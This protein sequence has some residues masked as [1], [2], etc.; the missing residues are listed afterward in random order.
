MFWFLLGLGA[1]WANAQEPDLNPNEIDNADFTEIPPSELTEDSDFQIEETPIQFSGRYSWSKLRLSKAICALDV[2]QTGDIIVMSCSG[3]VYKMLRSGSW[4]QVLGRSLESEEL[5]PEQILLDAEATIDELNTDDTEEVFN[6]DE[7]L[8]DVI[9]D[10]I[11]DEIEQSI[12]DPIRDR[13]RGGAQSIRPPLSLYQDPL[14]QTVFACRIEACYR[15]PDNGTTWY[16]IQGL[17]K[18]RDIIRF[19]T[20]LLAA[21]EQGVWWSRN[22]GVSWTLSDTGLQS[23]EVRSIVSQGDILLAATSEGAFISL[24]GVRWGKTLPPRYA[25][26]ASEDICFDPSSEGGLW[27]ATHRGILRSDDLLQSLYP[28]GQNPLTGTRQILSWNDEAGHLFSIG[29]DGVWESMDGGVRW[30]PLYDGLT[31]SQVFDIDVWKGVPIIGTEEGVFFLQPGER[32]ANVDI[33]QQVQLPELPLLLEAAQGELDTQL[34][35]IEIQRRFINSRRVPQLSITG[36]YGR[37]RSI[38]ADYGA[39][40]S[41]AND[42][43]QWGVTVAACFGACSSSSSSSAF[44]G[45]VDDLMV[46]DGD[47]YETGDAGVLPAAA[48]VLSNIIG[49]RQSISNTVIDLY[50]TYQRLLLQSPEMVNLSLFEQSLH[51]LEMDEVISRI[52]AVTDGQFYQILNYSPLEE[53]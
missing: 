45:D 3:L 23:L 27:V 31:A 5:D 12:F 8:V 30:S 20:T 53:P 35:G 34:S 7:E 1:F 50:T 37:D 9:P 21:T 14:T 29:S 19:K 51:Q 6:D 28:I 41:V 39:I 22:S 42:N 10:D 36:E 15:S 26:L 38:A 49:H 48:N 46:I 44:S 33:F 43:L 2:L 32:Q 40:Q 18:T 24:D 13:V 17:P 16:Q 4:R 47:V 25:D 52:D 11:A